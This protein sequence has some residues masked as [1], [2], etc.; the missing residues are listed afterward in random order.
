VNEQGAWAMK[1]SVFSLLMFAP[2]LFLSA[3]DLSWTFQW[4][5]VTHGLLFED[6]NLT[7]SAKAAIRDDIQLILSYNPSSNV[8]YYV[9]PSTSSYY[10]QFTGRMTIEHNRLTPPDFSFSLYDVYGGTNYFMINEKMCINYLAKIALTNQYVMAMNNC[11]NFLYMLST[12]TT[13]NMSHAE[14]LETAWSISSDRMPTLA[15]IDEREYRNGIKIW[16][17]FSVGSLISVLDFSQEP[18]YGKN[19]FIWKMRF[20]AKDDAVV[21][22]QWAAFIN[23]RWRFIT[24]SE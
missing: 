23:G 3:Q 24:T 16:Q 5:N 14:Y 20:K 18:S 11:S 4:D 6:T 22:T 17:N 21:V 13:N 8:I 15:D 7:V 2:I 19:W 9:F 12:V 10:G 1:K